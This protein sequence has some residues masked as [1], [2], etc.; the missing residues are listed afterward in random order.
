[1]NAHQMIARERFPSQGTTTHAKAINHRFQGEHGF[2]LVEIMVVVIIVLIVGAMAVPGV[3]SLVRQANLRGA[4]SEYAGLLELSRVSAIR[5]NRYYSTYILAASGTAQI[6][7]A[8]I[9]MLPKSLTGASGNGGT[10]IIAGDP[11]IA[12][13]SEVVQ[14]TVASAP[15]TADLKSQLLPAI[16]PVTPTDT[17]ATA[18]TFG[19]RGLPCT[20]VSLTGGTVCDS[21]GGP[22]AFWTFFQDTKSG[23]WQAVTITPA[24]RIKKWYYTGSAWS[25]L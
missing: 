21:S 10:S 25:K 17:S 16:T 12:F 6:A 23:S 4:A 19:P 18:A 2:S 15:N 3:V 13:P 5:D 11:E 7:E 22:T 24:G 8:Y 14:E 20:P 9:D 1:M